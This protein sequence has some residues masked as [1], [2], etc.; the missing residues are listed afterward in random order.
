MGD[1]GRLAASILKFMAC[2]SHLK[3]AMLI[4][5]CFLRVMLQSSVRAYSSEFEGLLLNL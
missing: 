2:I 3:L 1:F 4:A 5:G